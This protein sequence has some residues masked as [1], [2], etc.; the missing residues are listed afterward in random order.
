MRSSYRLWLLLLALPALAGGCSS[1]RH[2]STQTLTGYDSFTTQRL[3]VMP[4]VPS[5]PL[6]SAA[7]GVL[8]PLDCTLEQLCEV[9]D[10][11][12]APGAET[13]LAQAFHDALAPRLGSRLVPLGQSLRLFQGM[14]QDRTRDTLR[15]LAVRFGSAVGAD[16]VLVGAVWRFQD[17]LQEA[18]ASVGFAAY[19][20]EVAN[21]RRIWRAHFDLT[22]QSLTAD[23]REAPL[24][25]KGGARW[26]TAEELARY[27]V[28]QV[29]EDFP[30][31][32][33]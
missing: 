23:L 19:C 5:Q 12:I 30:R 13:V 11:A 20:V 32:P 17:R 26:L 18:G 16:H 27:G 24:F 21:A 1:K 33:P 7:G 9:I 14:A 31:T 29:M 8:P 6:E 25:F 4:I 2:A 28:A 10:P 15:S 22:Q 3:A